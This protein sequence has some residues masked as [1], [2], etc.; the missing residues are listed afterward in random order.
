MV[1]YGAVKCSKVATKK[2]ADVGLKRGP[3]LCAWPFCEK[4]GGGKKGFK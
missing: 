2:P 1:Q 4:N 3:K